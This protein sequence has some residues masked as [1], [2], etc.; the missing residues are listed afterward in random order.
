MEIYTQYDDEPEELFT[1]LSS[2]HY[3]E[4][5]DLEMSGFRDDLP[6][7]L[8]NLSTP[9]DILE[10]GC[11]SGRLSRLLTAAGHQLTGIDLSLPM[12]REATKHAGEGSRFCCMDMRRL[13][14]TKRFAAIIIP[15]NT[16]NL[17]ADNSDVMYC[18]EDS[19]RQLSYS[20]Q[21][22]LQVFTPTRQQFHETGSQFQFTLFDRPQ[23]GKIVKETLRT[24]DAAAG[25]ITMTERYKIRPMNG[26]E[27]NSNYSHTMLL[28]GNSRENWLDC[29]RAAGFT[30]ESVASSYDASPRPI[31]PAAYR[32]EGELSTPGDAIISLHSAFF[33]KPLT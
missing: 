9:S 3:R 10:L 31:F 17:L 8:S 5:Y 33:P 1:P 32:G 22:L 24:M 15:Y 12:L 27:P 18:L 6:F 11:G 2:E 20:G 7:Y 25:T 28:N 23:G 14:F 16:L 26:S 4:L 30:V 13:A 19:R 21:L 29:L